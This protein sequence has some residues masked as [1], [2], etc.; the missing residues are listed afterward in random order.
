MKDMISS[1]AASRSTRDSRA[2][3][4]EHF[5]VL[6][7]FFPPQEDSY[8][9]FDPPGSEAFGIPGK[10]TYRLSYTFRVPHPAGHFYR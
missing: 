6:L 9:R 7:E 2:M 8:V 3:N 1:L 4:L 5:R 10:A